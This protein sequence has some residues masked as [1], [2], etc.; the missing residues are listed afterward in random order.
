MY[1]EV[2]EKTI[3]YSGLY[4]WHSRVSDGQIVEGPL[5][6]KNGGNLE[7]MDYENDIDGLKALGWYRHYLYEPEHEVDENG[8]MLTIHDGT[9]KILFLEDKI[10]QIK[11]HRIK[12]EDDIKID[13]ENLSFEAKENLIKIDAKSIRSLREWLVQQ[14]NCPSWLK[15]YEE[16]AKN[17]RVKIIP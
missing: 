5:T 16:E 10:L 17:E 8:N 7:K 13:N 6:F 15:Q 1:K 4:Y 11:L 3:D 2:D 14:E 12:N 9:T